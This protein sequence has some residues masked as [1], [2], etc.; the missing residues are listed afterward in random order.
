MIATNGSASSYSKGD[1]C[2][3]HQQ[4]GKTKSHLETSTANTAANYANG[5]SNHH[6]KLLRS[7]ESSSSHAEHENS[8]SMSSSANFDLNALEIKHDGSDG[9]SQLLNRVD[10]STVLFITGGGSGLGEATARRFCTYTYL[11]L[12]QLSRSYLPQTLKFCHSRF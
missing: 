6:H 5:I 9:D 12:C 4:N 1:P 3:H 11:I 10:S 7:H 2:D 8:M